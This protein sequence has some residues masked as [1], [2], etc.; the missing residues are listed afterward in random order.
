MKTNTQP[1][2]VANDLLAPVQYVKGVGP[3][4]AKVLNRLGITT[5][6]D[7]LYYIP[8]KYLDRSQIKKISEVDPFSEDEQT[9]QGTIL[10][11]SPHRT[12]G[13]KYLLDVAIGDG[14]GMIIATWFN[15]AYLKDYFKKGEQVV[16][17]GKVKFYNRRIQLAG[18]EF[19]LIKDTQPASQSK[20]AG[21]PNLLHTGSIVPCY[22]LTEGIS[23]KVMRGIMK[24]AV[25]KYA[26]GLSDLF[27]SMPDIRPA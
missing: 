25:T 1:I 2:S 3:E 8:R 4:R 17:S 27:S 26:P 12:K 11:V 21:R 20:S 22:P 15:Q 16:L 19:E 10:A 18:P 7:L 9:V 23:Q 13:G 5:I 24:Q 14:S 6:R